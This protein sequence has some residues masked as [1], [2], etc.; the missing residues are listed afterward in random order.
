MY[1]HDLKEKKMKKI[2][3]IF[4]LTLSIIY[5]KNFTVSDPPMIYIYQFVS[6]DTTSIILHGGESD[7]SKSKVSKFPLFN[8]ENFGKDRSYNDNVVFG[9]PLNPKLV[10]AMVTSA[11]ASNKHI[12]IAGE[13]IQNRIEAD[14]FLKLMKSY[15]YPKRT[16]YLFIGEVNTISNQ[17]EI[18]IKLL[19]ISKQQIVESESFNLAFESIAELRSKINSI[20][21]PLMQRIVTPFIG[22]AY[23][24]VDSTSRDKI[25]WN[26]ISIRPKNKV[27]GFSSIPTDES[28][29]VPYQT[30]N[31]HQDFF[32]THS[33]VIRPYEERD[34]KLVID[35]DEDRSFLQGEYVFRGF[36][37][38]NDV[39]YITD[40]T[41]KP[42]DLN[43]IY[44]GLPK[45]TDGDGILDA[46]DAC[47]KVPGVANVNPSLHGCPPPQLYGDIRITNLWEGV[48]FELLRISD[49]ANPFSSESS[50]SF[51]IFISGELQNNLF[52]IDSDSFDYNYD[53]DN[54]SVTI[55]DLPLGKYLRKS[56]AM[57]VEA[58]PGK[59]YVNMF[60]D[61]DTLLLDK[62][63]MTRR[64]AIADQTKIQGREVIIY[65]DPFTPT[66]EDEYKLYLE[67]NLTHFTAAKIVGELHILGFPI[68]YTGKIRVEREGY[69]DSVIDIEAGLKKAYLMA[70]LTQSKAKP[71]LLSVMKKPSEINVPESIIPS[72]TSVLTESKSFF[73]KIFANCVTIIAS[74]IAG[75]S[76]LI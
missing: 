57:P 48:A 9:K 59:Y 22:S 12:N 40:F 52:K 39:P 27:V 45:D 31:L 19:D 42:G 32:E 10:S 18:D 64:T 25:R 76:S 29:Y 35:V 21:I 30:T 1:F 67:D 36:L 70:D 62:D 14:S 4:C 69:Y 37:K 11:V 28:D 55:F 7:E 49:N 15:E 46:D 24:R 50:D 38:N 20:I 44:I 51:N 6:Y 16:D 23:V 75:L 8:L 5:A 26:D 17:Y 63:G 54:K 2:F 71:K 41:I 72:E 33:E 58:F 34:Y 43:E 61:Y 47:P 68:N 73:G 53:K 56:S 60:F 66:S 13:S 3:T 74:A 65:F